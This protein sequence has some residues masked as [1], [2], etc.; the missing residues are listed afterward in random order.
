[1]LLQKKLEP[2]I[3]KLMKIM[4]LMDSFHLIEFL[5]KFHSWPKSVKN[6]MEPIKKIFTNLLLTQL[7]L[8]TIY[9]N[10]FL[11]MKLLNTLN[12]IGHTQ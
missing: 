3:L 12:M 1:M 6:A 5:V 10:Y 8:K 4:N 2:Q 9:I 11:N 7:F